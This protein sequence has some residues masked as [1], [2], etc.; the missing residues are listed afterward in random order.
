MSDTGNEKDKANPKAELALLVAASTNN[1]IGKN[2][3]LVWNLPNDLKYFKNL[4]WGFPVIMGRKNL[5]GGEQAPARQDQRG[6]DQDSWLERRRGNR[7][8]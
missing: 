4:T 6:G 8:S 7:S 2:N 5:R 3:H 1:V